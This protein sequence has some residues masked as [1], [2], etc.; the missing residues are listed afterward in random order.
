MLK[1]WANAKAMLKH[2][3]FRWRFDRSATYALA[4]GRYHSH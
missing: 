3:F 4:R 2:K 1:R